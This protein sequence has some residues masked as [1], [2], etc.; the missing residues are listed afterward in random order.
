MTLT[1]AEETSRELELVDALLFRFREEN[2]EL[3]GAVRAL[4]HRIT[5]LLEANNGFEQRARDAE[6]EVKRLKQEP[7]DL[8][9]AV[10]DRVTRDMEVMMRNRGIG[11]D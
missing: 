11:E 7:L 1:K 6:R 9:K 8:A 2:D 10:A 4:S 5:D 3:R